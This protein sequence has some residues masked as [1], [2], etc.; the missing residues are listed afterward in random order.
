MLRKFL[1]LL[2]LLCQVSAVSAE[3]EEPQADL[4]TPIT[5]LI[6]SS[7][8]L[9]GLRAY[10]PLE[11][12]DVTGKATV[13]LPRIGPSELLSITPRV[14]TRLDDD[15][16]STASDADHLFDQFDLLGQGGSMGWGHF[17]VN[18]PDGWLG[19]NRVFPM[20]YY[21]HGNGGPVP[22]KRDYLFQD[23][24][25]GTT[26]E[27]RQFTYQN[28]L[29]QNLRRMIWQPVAGNPYQGDYLLLAPS[30]RK[31]R[32]A[33]RV[34]TVG[35][36]SAA[37]ERLYYP[38][39]IEDPNGEWVE[40]HYH[41]DAQ[42][43]QT[44]RMSHMVDNHGRK[45]RFL[46]VSDEG[47]WYLD[48]VRLLGPNEDPTSAL[49]SLLARFEYASNGLVSTTFLPKSLSAVTDA[50]GAVWRLDWSSATAFRLNQI[51]VA[52]GG[53]IKLSWER[54]PITVG[55]TLDGPTTT[56]S[57]YRV[58]TVVMD[59]GQ[60]TRTYRY[61]WE[62]HSDPTANLI[63]NFLDVTLSGPEGLRQVTRYQ[64]MPTSFDLINIEKY[65]IN[66]P[67]SGLPLSR[68]THYAGTQMLEE[69]EMEP[70][71]L[72]ATPFQP[73]LRTPLGFAAGDALSWAVRPA[74]YSVFKD[75]QWYDISHSYGFNHRDSGEI[76]G[77]PNQAILVPL[78]TELTIRG[79]AQRF[80]QIFTYENRVQIGRSCQEN[81]ALAP[82][83]L[84]LLSSAVERFTPDSGPEQTLAMETFEYDL[85]APL[86]T[87]NRRFASPTSSLDTNTTYFANGNHRGKAERTWV[88]NDPATGERYLD[89][90]YGV[91][92]RIAVPL[93]PQTVRVVDPQGTFS[94]VTAAGVRTEYEHDS[95]GRVTDMRRSGQADGQLLYSPP[96]DPERYVISGM[97][98]DLRQWRRTDLDAWGRT[99]TEANE[100]I[101]NLWSIVDTRYDGLGRPST[102]VSPKQVVHQTSYDVH[103]RPLGLTIS[104]A[105][106]N[107]VEERRYTYEGLANGDFLKTETLTRGQE[108]TVLQTKTDMVGRVVETSTNK[109]RLGS[110]GSLSS[111]DYA[112]GGHTVF[113]Y[114][115]NPSTWAVTTTLLPYGLTSTAPRK[116]ER[117]LLKRLIAVHDP[118][119]GGGAITYDYD[120]RGLLATAHYPDGRSWH[121]SYDDAGRLIAVTQHDSRDPSQALA[122]TDLDYDPVYGFPSQHATELGTSA[123]RVLA[124]RNEPDPLGRP[125]AA[126]L[127]V[128]EPQFWR[129]DLARSLR[130]LANQVQVWDLQW[131][132]LDPHS[133]LETEYVVE[134]APL[135]GQRVSLYFPEI[136]R[137]RP[138]EPL[139]TWTLDQTKLMAAI[140]KQL[141]D[142]P[143]RQAWLDEAQRGLQEFAV[144][145]PQRS[146]RFRVTAIDSAPQASMVTYWWGDLA[147]LIV[148]D[149]DVQ[150]Y[151]QALDLD[152]R[153][154]NA[155][156]RPSAA[157]ITQVFLSATPT[158]PADAV[159]VASFATP[160]I[161]P[162]FAA[163]HSLGDLDYR[164]FAYVFILLDRDRGTL[165]LDEN[166]NLARAFIVYQG[167][168]SPT[169]PDVVVE[170]M[171]YA[172]IGLGEVYQTYA[173]YAIL[174]QNPNLGTYG[175]GQGSPGNALTR[176][177][178]S[179]DNIVSNDDLLLASPEC[180]PLGPMERELQTT[181]LGI[182]SQPVPLHQTQLVA[183]L[184]SGQG[185]EPRFDE[186]P[187]R[188]NNIATIALPQLTGLGPDL[189]VSH[190]AHRGAT[191]TPG[192]Y[193][194]D[195][196]FTLRNL[197]VW[198]APPSKVGFY[199]SSDATLSAG[200]TRLR[201]LD[202]RDGL[203]IEGLLP[204]W[205]HPLVGS[206]SLALTSPS[207]YLIVVA[208]VD[209]QVVESDEQNWRSQSF[210]GYVDLALEQLSYDP[211][212][213][214]YRMSVRNRGELTSPASDIRAYADFGSSY[215]PGTSYLI[216]SLFALPALAPG[217]A[218]ATL[219]TPVGWA[220]P[221][222]NLN[223]SLFFV[224]DAADV[225]H[226]RDEINN[227][228]TP[229]SVLGTGQGSSKPDLIPDR[230][231]FTH[232]IWPDPQPLVSPD[233]EIGRCRVQYPYFYCEM[234]GRSD[235]A[236]LNWQ[237][238][239][240]MSSDAIFG[241]ADDAVFTRQG[242]PF[243][244]EEWQTF[245]GHYPHFDP[246]KDQVRFRVTGSLAESRTANN[247]VVTRANLPD[248][249]AVHQV[250]NR[251]PVACG[252]TTT[253]VFMSRDNL[254]TVSSADVLVS[255]YLDTG[256][257]FA[258]ANP[259][260]MLAY[261]AT[262]MNRFA[263]LSGWYLKFVVDALNAVNEADETN[264]ILVV[265]ADPALYS[266]P[267]MPRG[268][269]PQPAPGPGSFSNLAYVDGS[270]REFSVRVDA[271]HY[272]PSKD[273]YDVSF[274]LQ[275]HTAK[276]LAL[277]NLSVFASADLSLNTHAVLLCSSL[278]VGDSA[279]NKGFPNSLAANAS[280]P[281]VRYRL[282]IPS[283]LA[284]K[285][286]KLLFVAN[287]K[288]VEAG[289]DKR[290]YLLF[291]H[292][293]TRILGV[294]ER[295]QMTGFGK[296]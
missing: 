40:I 49:G 82:Y 188:F 54:V 211:V 27:P 268:L 267:E 74:R 56:V 25:E 281:P 92:A 193:R 116:E 87:K 5:P 100:V 180:G 216:G 113:R 45:L 59:D 58:V 103:G 172:Y 269:P 190:F 41:L 150:V 191:G 1:L 8:Q 127:K 205:N 76:E 31:I 264:N 228:S 10:G 217:A 285:P 198:Q 26:P 159:P 182:F 32:F 153:I 157:S 227:I 146:Y 44:A 11:V 64:N 131:R 197:G 99:V 265:E 288:K 239:V 88:G 154:F 242:G 263:P 200:D 206:A 179:S 271:Y 35:D 155:G 120:D 71:F 192:N 134:L 144:L 275:N 75:G 19:E 115:Q 80:R 30:G 52:T 171:D 81:H 250:A 236:P 145:D 47:I 233:L 79:G 140:N 130:R 286:F 175:D 73:P 253:A 207:G 17:W 287:A 23:H 251:M 220:P 68:E 38:T 247:T 77:L 293:D 158:L 152:F 9:G 50:I 22:F 163:Y 226:E 219:T 178:Y 290:P 3:D 66:F 53:H 148:D 129:A 13:I 245:T 208:D 256:F 33:S 142:H 114:E 84:N 97:G 274:R 121:H 37:P 107:L 167:Q 213:K 156:T 214:R 170:A 55:R 135:V 83:A 295:E 270:A 51:I 254:T 291:D 78:E 15:H 238:E 69:W 24:Y 185:Q 39:R 42:G 230:W 12:N 215:Q 246:P 280:S 98:S 266:G 62:T 258:G 240:R 221:Q 151:G 122:L 164:G 48:Q 28:T 234:R 112:G 111:A 46:Y 296:E 18:R 70:V 34:W 93:Q 225:I 173:T 91:Q 43:N 183:S 174:N 169:K 6:S 199:H 137:H 67:T 14:R 294:L 235:S 60:T 61:T 210:Q 273:L 36:L 229:F 123:T 276:G 257:S 186:G 204:G 209:Q 259:A 128:D 86:P 132:P 284:D 223:T 176:L 224:V 85:V 241:N 119:Y 222:S 4:L 117:D 102:V 109:N 94:A 218:T 101:P 20:T 237:I 136:R 272:D 124:A 96:G 283:T 2:L 133:G 72:W 252:P 118:E 143:D 95:L 104:D 194:M 7:D 278:L 260:P 244:G 243:T 184:N 187:N 89:Y 181:A 201:L 165:E 105:D 166:D 231:G 261:D 21:E 125:T 249:M 279:G 139:I 289:D 29:D 149:F 277:S 160:V 65:A 168:S 161:Q 203:A 195:L 90:Q 189:V 255:L 248:V 147:N 292:K 106:G 138:E 141:A 108:T 196:D 16:I 282:R 57:T 110:G 177:Y 126:S 232:D 63:D 162:G 202:G 262:F 212:A